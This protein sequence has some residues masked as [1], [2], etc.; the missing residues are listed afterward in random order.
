M[1]VVTRRA[2]GRPPTP[3]NEADAHVSQ[4]V[5]MDRKADLRCLAGTIYHPPE[6]KCAMDFGARLEAQPARRANIAS[7]HL[8]TC[9]FE[10]DFG[11]DV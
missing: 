7:G 2:N 5:G 10:V 11:Y 1:R 6:A 9:R 4:H 8:A 3:F